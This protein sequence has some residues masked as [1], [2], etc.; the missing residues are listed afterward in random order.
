M[1]KAVI[2]LS[3]GLDSTT[4]MSVAHQEGYELYPISFNYGQRHQ[5]ELESAKAVASFYRVKEHRIFE[6]DYVGGSAL[7]DPSISVP[8]YQ[9]AEGIPVTY[10]PARNILFLSYALGYAEVLGAEAIFIGV[11]S[12]D[13]SGYPDCRPEFI[14]AFQQVV[15]VG[16]KAGVDGKAM[17]IRTPLI[18]L[19]KAATIQLAMANGAPLHLTTSCYQGGEKA[20]GICDS[21]TLRLKGFK[22]AGLVDPIPYETFSV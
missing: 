7:T 21:C 8:A 16:T 18:Q 10:V 11:S 3:G 17:T 2:L 1:K 19:S 14:E 5:R 12:I 6:I 22:E 4:C 20:C 9:E 15:K 13:Y